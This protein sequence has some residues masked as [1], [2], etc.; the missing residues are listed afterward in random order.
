MWSSL[1]ST[2]GA[3][4]LFSIVGSTLIMIPILV[5]L[6]IQGVDIDEWD[7]KRDK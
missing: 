6:R 3:R 4:L 2:W 5:I 7:H 1:L